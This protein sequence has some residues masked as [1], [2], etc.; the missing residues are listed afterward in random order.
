MQ[1][2]VELNN[3]GTGAQHKVEGIA[4]QYLSTG[5]FNIT[6]QHAFNG[7][8]SA[9]RHKGRGLNNAAG[10]SE[11]TTTSFTLSGDRLERHKTFARH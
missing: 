4:Q 2:T 1:I 8:V 6:R 5:R 7:A 10:E 9:H 3:I 11:P